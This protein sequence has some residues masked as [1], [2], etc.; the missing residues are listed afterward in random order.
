MCY[1]TAQ[2][3]ISLYTLVDLELLVKWI[4]LYIFH[5]NV[6]HSSIMHLYLTSL[7]PL[8]CF[9]VFDQYARPSKIIRRHSLTVCSLCM[10][11]YNVKNSIYTYICMYVIYRRAICVCYNWVSLSKPPTDN[12]NGARVCICICKYIWA[13]RL[14]VCFYL[15]IQND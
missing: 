11:W 13:I 12:F 10:T 3:C 1:Y 5:I 2:E 6:E 15:P 9:S 4:S 8:L 7:I 14:T